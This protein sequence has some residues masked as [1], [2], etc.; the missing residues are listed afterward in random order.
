MVDLG[1]TLFPGIKCAKTPNIYTTNQST[2]ETNAVQQNK[3]CHLDD[4]QY[5]S[6][7]LEGKLNYFDYNNF[8]LKHSSKFHET[9]CF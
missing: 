1:F 4:D 3:Y 2:G 9:G 6:K 7:E 8:D 5:P